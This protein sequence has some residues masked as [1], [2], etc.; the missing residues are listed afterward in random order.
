MMR[1]MADRAAERGRQ[2]AA[3]H[4][5]AQAQHVEARARTIRE[6]LESG[7]RGTVADAAAG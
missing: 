2:W 6:A 1:S 7:V 4:Y 5:E 3:A